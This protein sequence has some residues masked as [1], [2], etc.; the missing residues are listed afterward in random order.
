MSKNEIQFEFYFRNI[1]KED[2]ISKDV[3]KDVAIP[4]FANMSLQ[5]NGI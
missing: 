4:I 2:E 1:D 3:S 5:S